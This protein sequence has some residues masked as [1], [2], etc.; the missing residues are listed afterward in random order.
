MNKWCLQTALF[1]LLSLTASCSQNEIE[2]TAEPETESE[3]HEE[4]SAPGIVSLDADTLRHLNLQFEPAGRRTVAETIQ[5]T[6]VVGPNQTRV[7]HIRLLSR[8]RIEDVHVRPGDR[9]QSGQLLITYDN[10]ELGSWFNEYRT[11]L[12]AMDSANAEVEV[13][14]R[15]LERAEKLVA[16]GAIATSEVER[17]AADYKRAVAAIGNHNAAIAAAEEKIRRTGANPESLRGLASA[18]SSRVVIRSPFEGIV[19]GYEVNSGEIVET[20]ENLLTLTDLST[21]WVQANVSQRDL[22]AI[23]EGQRVRVFVDSYPDRAFSGTISYIGDVLDPATRTAQVRSE[24]AN[25]KRELKLDMF[26]RIQIPTSSTAQRLVVGSEAVQW[27]NEKPYV[28]VKT[29]DT[30]FRQ[31]SIELGAQGEDWVEVT[32]GIE[33]GDIVVVK[34][35]FSLKSAVLKEQIE[36]EGDHH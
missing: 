30:E 12:A 8:G 20:G 5:V 10:V 32:N 15:A 14:R 26:A 3:R 34:G 1:L 24:L 4:E 22:A 33:P 27:I 9:V 29:S 11:A 16:L 25:P 21:V 28:F 13:T 7:T 19:T 35:S 6:G 2:K 18:L 23:R 17:R 31:R 36:G